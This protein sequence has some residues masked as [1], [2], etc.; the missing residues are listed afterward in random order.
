MNPPGECSDSDQLVK[1]GSASRGVPVVAEAEDPCLSE[2]PGPSAVQLFGKSKNRIT[3]ANGSVVP[4]RHWIWRP[5][6]GGA[7]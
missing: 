6:G 7:G 1:T 2:Q 5:G 3:S 4:T